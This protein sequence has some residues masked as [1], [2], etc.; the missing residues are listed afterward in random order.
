MNNINLNNTLSCTNLYYANDFNLFV[1]NNY[2]S[3]D[4]DTE[5]KI[6]IGGEADLTSYGVGTALPRIDSPYLVI[7]KI[8]NI[9]NSN[10]NGTTV[11]STS[12]T[13][14]NSE[15]SNYEGQET[16]TRENLIDFNAAKKFFECY[17]K[18][19]NSL[20]STG[21]VSIVNYNQLILSGN[22]PSLNVF[23][24][25]CSN[26]Q[27]S[28]IAFSQLSEININI[29]EGST[30]IINANCTNATFPSCSIF[31]NN[32]DQNFTQA[33]KILWNFPNSTTL[34]ASGVEILGSVLAPFADSNMSDGQLNGN[35]ITN[36]LTGSMEYHNHPF[37]G[38]LPLSNTCCNS[39][40]NNGSKINICG[41]I[42]KCAPSEGECICYCD[43][44]CKIKINLYAYLGY[45]CK[46][47]KSTSI[48]SS[49][50]YCFFDLSPGY[51]IIEIINTC[52]NK[53]N[54]IRSNTC[55]NS[56][57]C[58]NV[59]CICSSMNNLDGCI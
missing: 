57:P 46:F 45:S 13:V 28:G 55:S 38:S 58:K 19:L 24:F 56:Q 16:Y 52:N 14:I 40:N 53:K 10:N 44:Q 27:N 59:V 54:Y 42:Y 8:M 6:A 37:N 30:V 47:I 36:N 12:G 9:T 50:H 22:N 20:T 31:V 32:N 43:Y 35:F 51:Y 29:P 49:G 2:T 39:N 1:L 26:I 33:Q 4:V 48:N 11:I 21:T 15:I 25:N 3:A 5:G 7:G 34:S 17:S 41:T 23:N 18:F